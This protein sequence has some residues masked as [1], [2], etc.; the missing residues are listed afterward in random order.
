MCKLIFTQ[1][2]S[3]VF[4]IPEFIF[5]PYTGHIIES[6]IHNKSHKSK[7]LKQCTRNEWEHSPLYF[8]GSK[9]TRQ[10]TDNL[11]HGQV[12]PLSSLFLCK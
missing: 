6:I 11:S 12:R 2:I 8:K 3:Q 10:S 7:A 5:E 9:V 1:T 4:K